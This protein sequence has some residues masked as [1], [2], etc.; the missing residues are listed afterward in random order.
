MH[1]APQTIAK[2]IDDLL[3]PIVLKRGHMLQKDTGEWTGLLDL[4]N[5]LQKVDVVAASYRKSQL[6]HLAGDLDG[7][8]Y[9]AQNVIKN[10]SEIDGIETLCTANANL[11]YVSRASVHF[12]NLLRVQNGRVNASLALTIACGSFAAASTAAQRLLKAGGRVEREDIIMIADASRNALDSLGV[13]EGHLRAMMDQ[14]GE[15]L[16]SRRLLWLNESPQ[17]LSSKNG[18]APFVALNYRLD[19]SPAEA[20]E[21]TW[22]LAER[23]VSL[24]LMPNSV[25]VAFIGERIAQRASQ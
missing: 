24:D 6:H 4:C 20:A 21:M 14:A 5:Q 15:L 8:E 12:E 2:Q 18:D 7:A 19:V 9:W 23:L 11:G 17:V 25:T 1:A 16:R 10:G 13:P 3:E 22:E